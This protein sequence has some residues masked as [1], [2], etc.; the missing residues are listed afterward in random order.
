MTKA[1]AQSICLILLW[2]LVKGRTELNNF[3][4]TDIECIDGSVSVSMICT[5]PKHKDRI[6]IF[7]NGTKI[8]S[9]T[10]FYAHSYVHC[11]NSSLKGVNASST[12]M[13]NSMIFHI[14]SAETDLIIGEWVCQNGG[15]HDPSWSISFPNITCQPQSHFAPKMNC[16]NGT[17][18]VKKQRDV[19]YGICLML[20][21]GLIVLGCLTYRIAIM[22]SCNKVPMIF[23][24]GFILIY[25]VMYVVIVLLDM[26]NYV[27]I[28]L[29]VL[30]CLMSIPLTI[31]PVIGTNRLKR[32]F[33]EQNRR[34][35][36]AWCL[37]IWRCSACLHSRHDADPSTHRSPT[38][39]DTDIGENVQMTTD[40]QTKEADI[41]LS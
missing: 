41:F 35:V 8:T 24:I 21:P 16:S 26:D 18:I 13:N 20:V 1:I 30:C 14:T 2:S 27:K 39:V 7:K 34:R 25:L 29:T 9:C 38:Q 12:L 15:T 5:V 32:T 37:Y 23:L 3:S 10:T 11:T 4:I 33:R 17:Y 6:I 31:F 22:E 28:V 19:V 40:T 36:N